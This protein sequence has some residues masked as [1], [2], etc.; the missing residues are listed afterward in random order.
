MFPFVK[1]TTGMTD[2]E[3]PMIEINDEDQLDQ[4]LTTPS[5]ALIEFMRQLRG[6]IL[7]LGAGGK[8]GPSL[9]VK[10]RR[11]V[12]E[13]GS[14][15]QV[16]AASRFSDS[17]SEQWLNDQ[18]VCT[19]KVDLLDRASVEQ[20][21]EAD[22]IIFLVGSKF[23]TSTNPS[24]TWMANTIVPANVLERFPRSRFVALSTGNVYPF[25]PIESGGSCET[26]P[27]GPIGEYA[28]AAL[29]RERVFQ[30][31]SVANGTEVVLVR[32]NY[33]VDLRY[34]VLVD[35]ATKV[36]SGTPIDLTCGYLNCVWQGDANDAILRSL[37]L[38]ASP[39]HVINLTGEET[40]SVRS[41]AE[42]F[43]K[44]LD[45]QVSFVGEEAPTA[46]LSNSTETWRRLG[47]PEISTN[48]ILQQ[49]A[50]WVSRDGRLLNKP[51]HFE[52]RNG[53]F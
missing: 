31:Y 44:L 35:I 22:N 6:D 45:K 36:Q 43:G 19:H 21:P 25:S 49:T 50:N 33:A 14:D 40:L 42:E 15:C 46:L 7:I 9:A 13:A 51:T 37:A 5:Q 52:V 47:T 24:Q 8:M 4:W 34:G 1:E 12:T 48:T 29:G 17:R 39:S 3:S 41:I 38:A 53:A 18:G 10:A 20:L 28:Q 26:D 27:V 32:L 11:A 23:G 16:I 30:H 2:S